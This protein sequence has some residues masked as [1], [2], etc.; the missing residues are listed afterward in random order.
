VSCNTYLLSCHA[1]VSPLND[2]SEER[3]AKAKLKKLKEEAEAEAKK[4]AEEV[5]QR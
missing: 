3:E 4:E 2:V 5:R 1:F